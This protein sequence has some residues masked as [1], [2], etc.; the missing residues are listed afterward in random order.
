V[1][2]LAGV[3]VVQGSLTGAAPSTTAGSMLAHATIA[4]VQVHVAGQSA[5]VVQVMVCAWHELVPVGVVVQPPSSATAGAVLAFVP[6]ATPP[7]VAP[8]ALPALP[9]D[10]P[11]EHSVAVSATQLN[12]GPQSE[13]AVQGSWYCATHVF[14]VVVTHAPASCTAGAT[15]Q[16]GCSAGH[17]GGV[18][19]PGQLVAESV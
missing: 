13:L 19:T 1:Q 14:E 4:A 5:S 16:S 6:L 18:A 17:F 7:L 8:L 10:P 11:P 3:A 12:P 15:P 9:A 2:V